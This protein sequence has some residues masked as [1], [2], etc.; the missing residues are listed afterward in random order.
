MICESQEILNSILRS[1]LK[2]YPKT[3]LPMFIRSPDFVDELNGKWLWLYSPFEYNRQQLK[4]LS[5]TNEEMGAI[6]MI[7]HFFPV[8]IGYLEGKKLLIC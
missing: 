1:V 7:E 6:Q 2:K 8:Q 4:G 3:C 5:R